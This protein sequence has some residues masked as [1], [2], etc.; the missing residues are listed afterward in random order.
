M[1]IRKIAII[2]TSC[3][4]KTTLIES[5]SRRPDVAIVPEQLFGA[6]GIDILAQAFHRTH[7]H[8]FAFS[9]PHSAIEVI[10]WRA[11]VRCPVN[12]EAD[13]KLAHMTMGRRAS[14]WRRAFFPQRGWLEVPVL[15][16]GE[17]ESN[18]RIDGPAIVES[19]FTSIVI[20]ADAAFVRSTA[21]NLVVTP[22]SARTTGSQA[23]A[24]ARRG[25]L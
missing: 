6:G 2:G 1:Q 22:G 24:S 15:Q 14:H 12:T 3:T 19:P 20:D 8:I 10:A 23:Y 13:L 11:A 21:G 17:I 18:K 9:D 25:R 5:F 16:F 4:G 7:E